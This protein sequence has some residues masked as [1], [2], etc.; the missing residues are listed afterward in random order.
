MLH[1]WYIYLQNWVT[2]R[3]HVG[4][5]SSTMEH[6]G[7]GHLK[8]QI[9]NTP[10][11]WKKKRDPAG[12]RLCAETLGFFGEKK[13]VM[14]E[15]K[16]TGT[17]TYIIFILYIYIYYI[18]ILVYCIWQY[19]HIHTYTIMYCI[20]YKYIKYLYNI[21]FVIGYDKKKQYMYVY[22]IIW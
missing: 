15:R 3:A 16:G 18:H 13:M 20:M 12:H 4:K 9:S 14:V 2:F 10:G 1:V 11:G 6:M 7:Y 21:H 22:N 8:Y 5:Y 19:I 17:Y